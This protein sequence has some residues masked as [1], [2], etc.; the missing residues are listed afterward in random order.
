[1]AYFIK[2]LVLAFIGSLCPAVLFN[3]ERKKFFWLGLSGAIG[4]LVF[5]W[6]ENL[7]G[8]VI[9]STFAGALAV[10]IYSEVMARLL[11]SPST[12]FSILGIFPLVPGLGAYNTAKFI[13]E[14]DLASAS[15]SGIE[16]IGS[17][18]AIAIGIMVISAVIRSNRN[19]K[20]KRYS[21]S[22]HK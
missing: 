1:M 19:L 2:N 15:A 4:W 10:G 13:V 16:T 18:G 20:T 7:T 6:M 5:K 12:V 8:R 22:F 21:N 14:G 17:A 3:A 11:K 9:L